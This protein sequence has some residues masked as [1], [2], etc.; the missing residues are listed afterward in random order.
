MT[1]ERTFRKNPYACNQPWW[2]YMLECKG[3]GIYTGIALDVDVRFDQHVTGK[4]AKYTR[5]N[6]PIRVVARIRYDTHREAAQAE[7]AL[8][9]L[10][11]LEKLRWAYAL[12]GLVGMDESA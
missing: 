3:G 8:K 6:P 4:G 2:L 10:K 1:S 9:R 5:M 7:V 12:A 11:P